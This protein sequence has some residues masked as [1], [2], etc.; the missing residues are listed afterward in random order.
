MYPKEE[1]LLREIDQR[2]QAKHIRQQHNTT[3][4]SHF[5]TAFSRNRYF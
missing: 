5:L 1:N 4:L 2:A 3:D